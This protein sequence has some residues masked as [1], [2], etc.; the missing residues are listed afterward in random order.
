MAT[1]GWIVT[2][3]EYSD[4]HVVGVFS[5]CKKAEAFRLLYLRQNRTAEVEEV[6]LDP[7][8]KPRKETSWASGPLFHTEY[9]VEVR[10]C[11]SGL[12]VLELSSCY[13]TGSGRIITLGICFGRKVDEATALKVFSEKRA[14]FLAANP[15]ITS[16]AALAG[17]IRGAYDPSTFLKQ[18]APPPSLS[19]ATGFLGPRE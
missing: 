13:L 12:A 14:Q 17:A 16:D 10:D 19:G 6:E 4:Y 15:H 1:M 9:P 11:G 3:G 7:I 18:E 8:Y 5:T 2:A